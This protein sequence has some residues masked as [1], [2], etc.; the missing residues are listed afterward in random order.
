MSGEIDGIKLI[1]HESG[2]EIVRMEREKRDGFLIQIDEAGRLNQERLKNGG[3]R[4][5]HLIG[6]GENRFF[7]YQKPV[8]SEEIS[9]LVGEER[10]EAWYGSSEYA[11]HRVVTKRH[12]YLI[13]TA[14]GERVVSFVVGSKQ[15]EAEDGARKDL[16][17][18]CVGD[19]NLSDRYDIGERTFVGGLMRHAET[20]ENER[21]ERVEMWV[22]L[23][24]DSKNPDHDPHLRQPWPYRSATNG[25]GFYQERDPFAGNSRKNDVIGI[26]NWHVVGRYNAYGNGLAEDVG[27]VAVREPNEDQKRVVLDVNGLSESRE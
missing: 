14:D 21:G 16:P 1:T 6:E 5:G 27:V 23:M 25:S 17:P 20:T 24:D 4:L 19:D 26:M 18:E 13:L 3:E 2:E 11:D 7:V 8:E 22:T 15:I 9:D 10:S 12:E